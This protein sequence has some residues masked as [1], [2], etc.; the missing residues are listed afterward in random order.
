MSARPL[1]CYFFPGVLNSVQT[2]YPCYKCLAPKDSMHDFFTPFDLRHTALIEYHVKQMRRLL[3]TRG[4][5]ARNDYRKYLADVPQMLR[6]S[7]ICVATPGSLHSVQMVESV[8]RRFKDFDPFKGT[9]IDMMH[10][11]ESGI[12]KDLLE[13]HRPTSSRLCLMKFMAGSGGVPVCPGARALHG[14]Q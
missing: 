6:I 14:S 11:L 5:S 12:M 8:F 13:V 7:N 1:Y 9:P 10:N 4:V 2:T 3:R